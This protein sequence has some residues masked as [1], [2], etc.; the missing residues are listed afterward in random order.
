MP[1][2]SY[3]MEIK[4]ALKSSVSIAPFFFFGVGRPLEISGIRKRGFRKFES[5]FQRML[6]ENRMPRLEEEGF[7]KYVYM[8]VHVNRNCWNFG[9]KYAVVLTLKK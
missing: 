9:F 5:R 4:H 8:N 7:L 2:K 1:T 3:P 6:K